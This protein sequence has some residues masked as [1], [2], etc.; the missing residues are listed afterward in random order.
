M[1]SIRQAEALKDTE[2]LDQLRES[3]NQ[4]LKMT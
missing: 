1:E 2:K 4:S 3:F